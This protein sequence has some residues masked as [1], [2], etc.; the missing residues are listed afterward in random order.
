MHDLGCG[1]MSGTKE[2]LIQIVLKSFLKKGISHVIIDRRQ[3]KKPNGS[4][5]FR[6][7]LFAV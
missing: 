5:T 7:R 4:V 1:I 6:L 2:F 3:F